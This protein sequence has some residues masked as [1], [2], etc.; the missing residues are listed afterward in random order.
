MQE[1]GVE[2]SSLKPQKGVSQW[3]DGSNILPSGPADPGGYAHI[4][5]RGT[6]RQSSVPVGGCPGGVGFLLRDQT[7]LLV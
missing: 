1:G 6:R 7:S 5:T 2:G 3:D 4:T